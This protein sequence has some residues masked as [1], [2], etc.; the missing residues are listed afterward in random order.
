MGTFLS[1]FHFDGYSSNRRHEDRFQ[2]LIVAKGSAN[3]VGEQELKRLIDAKSDHA[4]LMSLARLLGTSLERE[5]Y[6]LF[7]ENLGP[8][9]LFFLR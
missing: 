5:A 2:W 6:D 8:L 7:I 4:T 9:N 1:L 3:P